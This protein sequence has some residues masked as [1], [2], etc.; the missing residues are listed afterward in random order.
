MG[1]FP[2]AVYL[3]LMESL[4]DEIKDGRQRKKHSERI[5]NAENSKKEKN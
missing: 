4:K 1:N 5:I 3:R 2:I